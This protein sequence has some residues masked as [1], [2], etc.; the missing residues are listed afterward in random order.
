[1]KNI[2][3]FKPK[4]ETSTLEMI[5]QGHRVVQDE[6]IE[7]MLEMSGEQLVNFANLTYS[8]FQDSDMPRQVAQRL[9]LDNV[10]QLR[11]FVRVSADM[12]TDTTVEQIARVIDDNRDDFQAMVKGIQQKFGEMSRR[13]RSRAE[14]IAIT[15]M[16]T[17]SNLGSM[18][19]GIEGGATH[20]IWIWSGVGRDFH[21]S[22]ER[23][24]PV[25]INQPFI[26]GLGSRLMFPGDPSAPAKER[27]YCRCDMEM[28]FLSDQEA[29]NLREAA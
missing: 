18:Q 7:G 20:K 22:I 29:A 12:I 1:M 25:P 19:G 5:F 4:V 6:Y 9:V 27:I 2:L 14:R 11:S 21:A 8:T 3:A 24:G 26:S 16:Q 15:E 23:Q 13:T 17:V 10:D 28:L